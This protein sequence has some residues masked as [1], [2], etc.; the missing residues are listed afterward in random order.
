MRPG[1][2]GDAPSL[3]LPLSLGQRL[4]FAVLL[5]L[6]PGDRAS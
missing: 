2:V 5:S 1:L 4:Y 3:A 6:C